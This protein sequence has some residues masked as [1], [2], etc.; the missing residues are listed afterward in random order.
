[1]KIKILLMTL[2]VICIVTAIAISAQRR[3]SSHA[4]RER[5]ASS[6][7]SSAA[8]ASSASHAHDHA[9]TTGGGAAHVPAHYES[10]EA[11]G[12]LAPT[13]DP[14]QFHGQAR[15]AYVV[16]RQIPA[17]LAQLPCYCHCDES[18]GHR[19]L[20]SCYV[21]NHASQ[22]AVCVNEALTAYRL[23]RNEGLTP[24]QVRERIIAEY[25]RDN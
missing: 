1:M 17:T 21:D 24:A 6:S 22:C 13:L 9:P 25:G 2:G 19:S 16:A 23:Q 4:P 8:P 3:L 10:T 7:A 12:T 15:E 5:A 18:M 20:H 14:Q 11:A